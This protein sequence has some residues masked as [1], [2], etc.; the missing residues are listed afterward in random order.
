MLIFA[1][2]LILTAC[3]YEPVLVIT[4]GDIV[5]VIA[6]GLVIVALIVIGFIFLIQY[7]KNWYNDKTNTN[8]TADN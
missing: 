6:V 4:L 1:I 8:T 2:S 3:N 7:L 5:G